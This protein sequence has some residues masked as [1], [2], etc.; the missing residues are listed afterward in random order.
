MAKKISTLALL[1]FLAVL[2]AVAAAA[3]AEGADAALRLFDAD[4]GKAF[5]VKVGQS[6]VVRLAG[7]LKGERYGWRLKPIEYLTGP[8]CTVIGHGVG[9]GYVDHRKPSLGR[10]YT[11]ELRTAYPG[12]ANITLVYSKEDGTDARATFDFSLTV[13][14]ERTRGF[15]PR[16]DRE[17]RIDPVPLSRMLGEAV[18]GKWEAG[19]SVVY[20]RPKK[21]SLFFINYAMSQQ[22]QTLVLNG[23]LQWTR[24]MGITW[25]G[26]GWTLVS[27]ANAWTDDRA[28]MRQIVAILERF[29]PNGKTWKTPG[30]FAREATKEDR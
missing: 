13:T 27:D 24:P 25:A 28:E 14:A 11:V 10:F 12:A 20:S 16:A 9:G 7:K 26:Y 23:M 21:G 4:N 30:H 8:T 17:L 1:K 18:G 19:S 5:T 22:E 2:A 15:R 3:P 29:C 6:V